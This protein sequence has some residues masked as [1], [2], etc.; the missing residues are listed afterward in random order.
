[1]GIIAY[2][3]IKKAVATRLYVYAILVDDKIHPSFFF[4]LRS[5]GDIHCLRIEIQILV[6]KKFD[7]SFNFLFLNIFL[8]M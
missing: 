3:L 6:I 4:Q 1:M 8:F 2:V 5:S 7:K